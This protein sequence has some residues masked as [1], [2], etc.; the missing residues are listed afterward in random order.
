MEGK[1]EAHNCKEKV[2]GTEEHAGEVESTAVF[3]EKKVRERL[4]E[5]AKSQEG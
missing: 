3:Q 4:I 5:L 2:G 1:C